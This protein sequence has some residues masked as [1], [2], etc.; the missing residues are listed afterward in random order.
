MITRW[1]YPFPAGSAARSRNQTG[2]L[3][4]RYRHGREPR[5]KQASEATTYDRKY[6]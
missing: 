6:R 5:E 1:P 2:V 3:A 4:V